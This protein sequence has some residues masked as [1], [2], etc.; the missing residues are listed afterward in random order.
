MSTVTLSA[1]HIRRPDSRGPQPP[2]YVVV[3]NIITTPLLS[4]S[5]SLSSPSF[6]SSAVRSQQPQ[7]GFVDMV[8]KWT[9]VVPGINKIHEKPSLHDPLYAYLKQ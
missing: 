5:S 6:P 4:S 8:N 3:P 7:T 9:K 1:E 2:R